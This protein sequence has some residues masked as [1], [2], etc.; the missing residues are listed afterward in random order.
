MKAHTERAT[1]LPTSFLTLTAGLETLNMSNHLTI[2]MIPLN[3]LRLPERPVRIHSKTKIRKLKNSLER[4]G[5][6]APLLITSQGQIVDG[7]ARFKAAKAAG[8]EYISC[9]DVSHLSDD[10]KR[11]VSLS[12]NRLQ[13]GVTWDRAVKRASRMLRSTLH[14][15]RSMRSSSHRRIR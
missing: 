14:R 4:F 10:E 13:E 5:I 6:L 1:S 8:F 3:S 2:K 15:S 12:M 9:I 7:V 11:V